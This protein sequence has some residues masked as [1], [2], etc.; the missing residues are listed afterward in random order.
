MAEGI[1]LANLKKKA[2]SLGLTMSELGA[3]GGRKR[4]ANIKRRQPKQI[5]SDELIS[6]MW[7]NKD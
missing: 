3:R 6:D 7:W 1:E 2:E 4:A 5:H